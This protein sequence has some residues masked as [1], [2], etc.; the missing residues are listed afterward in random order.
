MAFPYFP[1]Q[2]TDHALV[3]CT[4]PQKWWVGSRIALLLSR[5]EKGFELTPVGQAENI[6]IAVR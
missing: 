4:Q 5:T 2:D 1:C 6:E 3:L